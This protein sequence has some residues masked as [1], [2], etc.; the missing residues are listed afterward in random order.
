MADNDKVCFEA[1]LSEFVELSRSG[2]PLPE[3]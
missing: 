1:T 3:Q 2:N